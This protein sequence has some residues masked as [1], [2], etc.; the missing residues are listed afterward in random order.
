MPSF[1]EREINGILH[2]F[3]LYARLSED[4]WPTIAKLEK[5]YD[6]PDLQYLWQEVREEYKSRFFTG[7]TV[8]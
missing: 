6:S 2:T 3:V 7:A 5:N 8:S 1:T 4:R